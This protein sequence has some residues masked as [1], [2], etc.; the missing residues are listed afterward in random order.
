MYLSK[1]LNKI[2]LNKIKIVH[3][4]VY[5]WMIIWSNNLKLKNPNIKWI[6]TYHA[7]YFPEYSEGEFLDWQKEFNKRLQDNKK[8]YELLNKVQQSA[9]KSAEETMKNVV[10]M[11]EECNDL[12]IS[13]VRKLSEAQWKLYE[14]FRTE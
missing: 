10:Q 8:N 11:L 5:P 12:Y 1:Y 6:H 2:N 4:H 9:I 7:H 14:A 3:S 13:D